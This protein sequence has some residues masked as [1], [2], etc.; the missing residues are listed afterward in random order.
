MSG[1][2][3]PKTFLIDYTLYPFHVLVSTDSYENVLKRL[4]T[5]DLEL[6]D[7][8][9][10]ALKM[11]G[12][13]RCVMIKD[14]GTVVRLSNEPDSPEHIGDLVHECFHAVFFLFNRIGI[15]LSRDSDEAFAYA[16]EYLAREILKQFGIKRKAATKPR[17]TKKKSDADAALK[18]AWQAAYDNHHKK[19]KKRDH[20]KCKPY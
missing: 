13:A 11:D 9:I 8:D 7:E 19:C 6:D 17:A 14:G 10:E 12:R 5:Y 16:I 3:K 20:S 4:S 15:S 2:L 1:L 18:K